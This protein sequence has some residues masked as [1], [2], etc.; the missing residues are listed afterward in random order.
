MNKRQEAIEIIKQIDSLEASIAHK[1]SKGAYVLHLKE[2][3]EELEE[4]LMV[5]TS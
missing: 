3:L 1:D 4:L 2:K 5:M